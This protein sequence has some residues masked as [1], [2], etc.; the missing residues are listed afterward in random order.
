MFLFIINV[1]NLVDSYDCVV[2]VM[3][4]YVKQEFWE[5]ENSEFKEEDVE[6]D[7]ELVFGDQIS[8]FKIKEFLEKDIGNQL[9]MLINRYDKFLD[10]F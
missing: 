3:V 4:M 9:Y 5:W 2:F 10:I 1:I 6:I 8:I 7:I